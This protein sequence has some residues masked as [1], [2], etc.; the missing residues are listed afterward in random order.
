MPKLIKNKAVVEDNWQLL[1]ATDAPEAAVIPDGEVIVPLNVWKAQKDQLQ[2]RK[3]TLGVWLDSDEL[4]EELATDAEGFAVIA[5][6]FPTFMDG[7]AFTTA[8]LLRERFGY[9]GDIRAVGYIIRDQLFYMSR[10]GFTSFKLPE[11]NNLEAALES[12]ND[13]TESYQAAVDQP[14]PLFRRRA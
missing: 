2:G 9:Q 11:G 10:C 6:N 7:R 14:Q 1:E 4:A 8:R 3:N 12:F 5:L 13:F